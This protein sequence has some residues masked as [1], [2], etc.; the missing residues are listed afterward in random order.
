MDARLRSVF[1]PIDRNPA[2]NHMIGTLGIRS[3]AFLSD[4]SHSELVAALHN[5]ADGSA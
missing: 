2:N 4:F 1:V 5:A 3:Y